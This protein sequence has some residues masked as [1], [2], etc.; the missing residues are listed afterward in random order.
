M[1]AGAGPLELELSWLFPDLYEKKVSYL[2]S[3]KENLR[4]CSKAV[5]DLFVGILEI[6]LRAGYI[7]YVTLEETALDLC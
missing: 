5:Q 7:N 3:L 6:F 2:C 1:P 4:I